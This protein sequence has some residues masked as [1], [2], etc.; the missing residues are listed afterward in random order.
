MQLAHD[1]ADSIETVTD[2][3]GNPTTFEY[4]PF[5]NVVKEV[6]ANGGITTAHL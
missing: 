4:D 3:L 2:A 5:G 1:P 6:D